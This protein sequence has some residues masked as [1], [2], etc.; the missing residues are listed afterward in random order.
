M[1]K[2]QVG[3]QPLLA[4]LGIQALDCRHGKACS[5][6]ADLR[7]RWELVMI[8]GMIKA[9]SVFVSLSSGL[10]FALALKRLDVSVL[11]D[12]TEV[13]EMSQWPDDTVCFPRGPWPYSGHHIRRPNLRMADGQT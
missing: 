12:I 2:A 1:D 9:A 13:V 5:F 8:R 3:S 6:G 11:I 7:R 10:S 4:G